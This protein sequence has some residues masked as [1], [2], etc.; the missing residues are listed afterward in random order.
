MLTGGQLAGD[1]DSTD[2]CGWILL[3]VAPWFLE[4]MTTGKHHRSYDFHAITT[5]FSTLLWT[6]MLANGV[7]A[8]TRLKASDQAMLFVVRVAYKENK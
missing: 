4:D 3:L 1:L 2:D 8:I 5:R 7:E 6:R